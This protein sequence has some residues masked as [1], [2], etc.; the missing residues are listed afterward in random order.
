MI[1]NSKA[2]Q[3]KKKHTLRNIIIILIALLFVS[4]IAGFFIYVRT[5]RLFPNMPGLVDLMTGTDH[6]TRKDHVGLYEHGNNSDII[7]SSSSESEK[8]V[9]MKQ[10]AFSYDLER[11]PVT[12]DMTSFSTYSLYPCDKPADISLIF[13]QNDK[14]CGTEIAYHYTADEMKNFDQDMSQVI[15]AVD[16]HFR[17]NA[18]FSVYSTIAEKLGFKRYNVMRIGSAEDTQLVIQEFY[19]THA[20]D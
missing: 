13:D 19:R 20:Y 1:N 10:K 8:L 7:G 16:R 5:W 11:Q 12:V 9:L 14:L 6:F 17:Q 18:L 2:A 15:Y 4:L 3:N